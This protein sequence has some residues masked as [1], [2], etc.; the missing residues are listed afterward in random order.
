MSGETPRRPGMVRVGPGEL[1]GSSPAAAERVAAWR[2]D[3]S[4]EAFELAREAQAAGLV[5]TVLAPLRHVVGEFQVGLYQPDGAL[6]AEGS[7]ESAELIREQHIG[8]WR[9]R[10]ALPGPVL[11][12]HP[13]G[14]QDRDEAV[15][16]LAHYALACLWG[17][18]DFQPDGLGCCHVCCAPCA[19]L[20]Y[21]ERMGLLDVTV[22]AWPEGMR[23]SDMFVD[24]RVDRVWLFRQ[25][26]GSQVQQQCG[27]RLDPPAE[28]WR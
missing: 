16:M 12:P 14:P 20:Y 25:W 21:L 18:S 5:V 4:R 2:R 8:G 7:N 10:M 24:D 6:W 28:G 23:G 17:A 1:Y 13:D 19:A 3:G 11:E 27:H 26:T 22:R 15:S 9:R